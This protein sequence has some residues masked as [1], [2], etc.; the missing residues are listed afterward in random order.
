MGGYVA[1]TS[2]GRQY[3]VNNAI[4]RAAGPVTA[5]AS[6]RGCTRHGPARSGPRQD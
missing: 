4:H 2:T 6:R 1:V 3:A 5:L